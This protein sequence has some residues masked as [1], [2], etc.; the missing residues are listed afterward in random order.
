[1]KE[2]KTIAISIML[3]GVIGLFSHQ[4]GAAIGTIIFINK[5]NKLGKIQNECT[6][7]VSFVHDP[8]SEVLPNFEPGLRVEYF[9]DCKGT[10]NS[11]CW[12]IK[13]SISRDIGSCPPCDPD[14]NCQPSGG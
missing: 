13:G 12:A 9:D 1:M 11:V 2:F 8:H 3:I 7:K 14:P 6:G 5:A 4:A 10:L